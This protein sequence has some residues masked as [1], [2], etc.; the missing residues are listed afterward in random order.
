MQDGKF[1][2][3]LACQ[4]GHSAVVKLLLSN[5]ALLNENDKVAMCLCVSLFVGEAQSTCHKCL[6]SSS[7]VSAC[8]WNEVRDVVH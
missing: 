6:H 3:H 7:I 2:L 1:P 4:N 8:I 5:G